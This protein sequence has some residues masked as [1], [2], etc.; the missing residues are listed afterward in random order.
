MSAPRCVRL[1][2]TLVHHGEGEDG[3]VVLALLFGV[4]SE[5][6]VLP[7]VLEGDVRQQDGDVVDRRVAHKLHPLVEDAHVWLHPLRWDRR[8]AELEGRRRWPSI[9]CDS[10]HGTEPSSLIP[11]F[12]FAEAVKWTLQ[13]L[14][15]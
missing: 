5:A 12:Y 8:L 3:A 14:Y 2:L 4:A 13:N 10:E 11:K 15:I 7:V 1:V 6:R 9:I